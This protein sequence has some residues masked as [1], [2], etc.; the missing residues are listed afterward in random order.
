[1]RTILTN[2]LTIIV[3]S[4]CVLLSACSKNDDKDNTPK[5]PVYTAVNSYEVRVLG[6]QTNLTTG[7]FYSTTEDSVYLKDRAGEKSQKVDL[8]Y[9]FYG[10]SGDSSALAAPADP[11]FSSSG[12]Q[13]PHPTVKTWTKRNATRFIKTGVSL[14]EFAAISNDSI[15]QAYADSSFIATKM[16]KLQ[17]DDIIAFKTEAGKIGMY[18]VRAINLADAVSRAITI[19]VKIS[20]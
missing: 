20:K 4:G 19:D 10:P 5:G 3:A 17:T 12:E 6:S 11:I 15:F 1:M 16:V 8:V 7:S 13:Y 2:S 9:Y 18:R 14:T